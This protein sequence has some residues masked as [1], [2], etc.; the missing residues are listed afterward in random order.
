MQKELK[1]GIA[2]I[3]ISS[4]FEDK[5]Q[6]S[7]VDGPYKYF[8]TNGKPG[9]FLY[10]HYGYIPKIKLGE[11]VF[12]TGATW[13][14]YRNNGKCI[15]RTA[16]KVVIL[17]SDFKSGDIYIRAQGTKRKAEYPLSYPL[18]EVLMI[19][20]LAQERGVMVHS[21]GVSNKD[22]GLLFA[23][24]SQ[25]GKSTMANLWKLQIA[26][27]KSQNEGVTTLSDDRVI[28]R[29]RNGQFWIYGTPWHGDA[30][31]CSPEKA[32]L[33]KI[34]FLK[35]TK[36]NRIKKIAPMEATSRLIVCSFPTFWDKKG[37][38][39]TLGF[40]AELAKKI[41]CYELSFVPDES[42]LDFVRDVR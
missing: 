41:P 9:I 28:V 24:T 13:S 42:V 2:D 19:N 4:I 21:C 37:M 33:E 34:F 27:S 7:E 36:K 15:L 6:S 39:F 16:T 3:V 18:D 32:P 29:K 22:Q 38:E 5:I 14:F 17:E 20:L 11:R 40:C 26:N 8:L 23:G 31:V 12:D 10:T 30:K 1:V 25:M 35:H